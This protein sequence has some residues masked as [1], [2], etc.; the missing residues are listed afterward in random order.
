ME[1]DITQKP[2]DYKAIIPKTIKDNL[3]LLVPVK[4]VNG[5]SQTYIYLKPIWE[6]EKA[7]AK[8]LYDRREHKDV[9]GDCNDEDIIKAEEDL[10]RLT[11]K[12]LIL[13]DSQKEAVKS[14]FNHKITVITG[15][16]GTG[17]STICRCIYYLA[18]EKGLSVRMMSPTGKAAQVL[19]DKTKGHAATIHRSLKM[20]P[21]EDYGR[22][23]IKED[24]VIVDEFSMVGLDTLFA[25]LN[26]LEENLW[27]NIVFVGDSNQLPSVSPGNFLSDIVEADCANVVML[28]QIHR[29]D[30]N[31]YI[32]LIANDIAESKRVEE[33]PAE[34]SDIKWIDINPNTFADRMPDVIKKYMKKRDI[35][36][37]QIMAPMYRGDCGVNK[38]NEEIQKM[39]A[40]L[41]GTQDK[42]LKKHFKLFHVGDRVIQTKNNYDKQIF[43]GDM[44]IVVDL[45]RKVLDPSKSDQKEDFIVVNFYGD[46]ITF[47]GD[48][49]ISNLQLAWC[50][51]VHKY[52]G[53]Q[54]PY[55]IF[56]MA[57]EAH[58][59]MSKE[60]VYTAF[61]R[62]EKFLCIYG[63]IKMLRKAP[64]ES[65]V[66]KRYTNMVNIVKEMRE[67][68]KILQV[69]E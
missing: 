43:N 32:S 57:G 30:E 12:S 23:D 53:S 3:D 31:S 66:K 49:E 41:N 58:N 50:I 4:E 25:V 28:E 15:S 61:T 8:Y 38:I 18:H 7:I 62:A 35:N 51:T 34:A 63:N 52:Q 29:Q 59:M 26:A 60:L 1:N 64:H 24:I 5:E 55:I 69:M 47:F 11:G 56:V 46:D 27:C 33:I 17:K 9:K 36:D 16:G 37:L 10:R 40:E 44:G 22:E 68:R 65:V 14:A 13:D 67:N 2:Q 42:Y 6:K 20:M 19:S 54:S 39:M 48:D 21:G 45:G